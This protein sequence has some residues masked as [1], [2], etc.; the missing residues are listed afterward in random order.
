MLDFEVAINFDFQN[1]RKLGIFEVIQ[2]LLIVTFIKTLSYLN[3][4]DII[5]QKH[6]SLLQE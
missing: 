3:L 2:A 5:W 4:G 6:L 1:L